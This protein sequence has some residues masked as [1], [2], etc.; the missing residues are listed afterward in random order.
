MSLCAYTSLFKLVSFV[1]ANPHL[2]GHKQSDGPGL[3]FNT[4][5]LVR[6]QFPL[7]YNYLLTL[8][9]DPA[10]TTCAFLKQ[11]GIMHPIPFFG[12]SFTIYGPLLM[13]TL[14]CFSLFNGYPRLLALIGVEHEDRILSGDK[15]SLEVKLNEGIALIKR[16]ADK[17]E[18]AVDDTSSDKKKTIPTVRK[19]KFEY[20][21]SIAKKPSTKGEDDDN[22]DEFNSFRGKKSSKFE[23]V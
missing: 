2:G 22:D 13:V 23:A 11:M 10:T 20:H 15:M 6:L 1:P 3:L 12:S 4:Q 14:C 17:V 9:Y 18:H 7:C 5:I 16:Y 21:G 8:K 19:S